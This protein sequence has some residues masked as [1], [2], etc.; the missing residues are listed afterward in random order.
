MKAVLRARPS[1][2]IARTPRARNAFAFQIAGMP[3]EARRQPPTEDDEDE[4]LAQ[5]AM[6]CQ[7][8]DDHWSPPPPPDDEDIFPETDAQ[9]EEP[10]LAS[11][12]VTVPA[13]PEGDG[14]HFSVEERL[15]V[16]HAC[17]TV[18]QDPVRGTDQRKQTLEERSE[19]RYKE[20]CAQ[21]NINDD[22]RS[23]KAIWA[24]FLKVKH[25]LNNYY[26]D[27]HIHGPM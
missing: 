20:L 27:A 3:V 24:H 4:F 18:C 17:C 22:N 6:E 7:T 15:I 19:R 23:G 16:A 9:R 2:S 21:S 26:V 1:S 11:G 14:K 12:A 8:E 5:T 10:T 13:T 25:V